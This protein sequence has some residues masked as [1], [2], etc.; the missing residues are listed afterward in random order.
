M[1]LVYIFGV[2]MFVLG[3]IKLA[4]VLIYFLFKCFNFM[5]DSFLGLIVILFLVLLKGKLIIV[6]LKVI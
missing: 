1:G 6:Y 3:L 4:I 5:W 2:G